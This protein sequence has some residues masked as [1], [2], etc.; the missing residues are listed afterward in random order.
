MKAT[1]GELRGLSCWE[2]PIG[3]AWGLDDKYV[4]MSVGESF[5]KDICPQAD[6]I[7]MEGCGHFAQEDFG[8]R[9]A[10]NLNKFLRTTTE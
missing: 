8:L 7:T 4:P 1:A 3:V 10:E 5:V 2:K 9:V 6:F